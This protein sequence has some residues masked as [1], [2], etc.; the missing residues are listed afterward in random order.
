MNGEV[1]GQVPENAILADFQAAMIAHLRGENSNLQARN[2]ILEAEIQV[3]RRRDVG[4]SLD[5]KI[6]CVHSDLQRLLALNLCRKQQSG[7]SL[8][9]SESS[10]DVLD[11]ERRSTWTST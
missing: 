8:E 7:I 3:L 2:A 10:E 1:P 9:R 4:F 11:D 5:F 6:V